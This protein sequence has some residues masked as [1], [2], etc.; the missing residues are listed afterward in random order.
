MSNKKITTKTKRTTLRDVAIHTNVTP[1]TV[2]NVVHG[3]HKYVGSKTIAKIEKAIKDLNYR[4]SATSRKLRN[5]KEYS[6]GLV[7]M[8]E[9]KTFLVNPF[10]SHVVAGLS[11]YLSEKNYTLTIQGIT[12]EEFE[13]ASIF[14][15]AGTDA[16]CAFL[17][18]NDSERKK[19]IKYMLGKQQPVLVLQDSL[20]GIG[21][22]NDFA[23][24]NQDDE[25]GGELIASHILSKGAQKLLFLQSTLEW[26]AIEKRKLGV[27]NTI[28]K[29]N[30]AILD[31]VKF[32]QEDSFSSI[33]L[34]VNKYFKENGK[35]DAIIG[36]TD[37][38]AIAA[39]RY[40][41]DEGYAI[42]ESIM[43]AGFNGFTSRLFTTP[44]LTTIASPAYEIGQTAGEII[45]ERLHSGK[46][47]NRETLL[48]VSFVQGGSS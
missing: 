48:P 11:N 15:I 40:C 17:F 7:I 5:N 16:I 23:I 42:P 43:V 14:S 26:P 22:S 6:I 4:P 36:A 10:I 1:M 44:T 24:V 9:E 32:E 38:I 31:I 8:Y 3:K 25:R 47:S 20:V 39:L 27:I 2:S 18:G 41:Q 13:N 33:Q 28:S 35:P 19:N 29:S 21:R 37:A 12:K 46:F 34:A 30:S 45:L